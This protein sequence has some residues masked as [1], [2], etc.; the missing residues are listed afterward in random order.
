MAS[1][2]SLFPSFA[3]S[4]SPLQLTPAYSASDNAA[5]DAFASAMAATEVGVVSGSVASATPD[6]TMTVMSLEQVILQ[7]LFQQQMAQA[8]ANVASARQ[9]ASDDDD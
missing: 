7:G 4:Q 3:G 1:I 8:M 9:E 6:P 5:D 2:S